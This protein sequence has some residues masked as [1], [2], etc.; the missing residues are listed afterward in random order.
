MIVKDIEKSGEFEDWRR[1]DCKRYWVVKDI[2]KSG[3][4]EDLKRNDCKRCCPENLR[5]GT[6][7]VV[8]GTE[9]SGEFEDFERNKIKW[10]LKFWRNWR[11]EKTWL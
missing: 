8:K 4:F 3:E 5:I 10:N 11:L 6:E 9:T 1:N 7:T 2:G